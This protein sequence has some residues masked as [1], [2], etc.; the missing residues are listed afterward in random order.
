MRSIYLVIILLFVSSLLLFNC[1]K[2]QDE[3]TQPPVLEGVH[4][5]NTL[6]P[7]SPEF[8]G[9]LM[10]ESG[11]EPCKKCHDAN[12][13]GGLAQVSCLDCHPSISVHKEGLFSP[14][15]PN[16]HGKYLA[17]N[18]L[19]MS[20]CKSCHGIEYEGGV[21][22]PGCFDCHTGISVHKI[23]IISPSSPD[24]HGNFIKDQNWALNQCNTCHGEDYSG[25]LVSTSCNTCHTGTNGPE[26]CNTC[27]G[28]FTDESK[29]APPSNLSDN[30]STSANGVGAH[31]THLYDNN[32]SSDI[33]CYECHPKIESTDNY[34]FAHID[35]LP[36][37]IT[38]GTIASSGLTTPAYNS[39][40]SCS[41]TYCHG[42]FEF[43][44]EE[45]ENKH[46]YSDSLIVGN[47]FSPLWTTVDGTQA[48]CGTCHGEI[49]DDG[50]LITPQP[51]GHF[52]Q[53]SGSWTI[54]QCVFC[55]SST[56]NEDGSLNKF[57]HMNG[58]KNLN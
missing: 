12:F 28:D 24:F 18:E 56:Y 37:E 7:T 35:G 51:I 43:N 1:S 48:A 8:H 54:D 4:S 55:H 9:Q 26:A 45:S 30:S 11:F 40:L 14:S 15:S 53:S 3:I 21:S 47:N 58:E 27:H 49:D 57:T 25:G 10:E 31:S 17:D 5:N 2:V 52:G 44:K 42:N 41:N 23:G 36:A 38:F 16:F 29:I 19:E 22:S 50:N 32:I 20:K 46:A 6:N 34:V 33:S 39:N 13:T